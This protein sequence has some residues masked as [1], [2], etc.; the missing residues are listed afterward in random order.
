MAGTFNLR[1][2]TG[3]GL[4]RGALF[5]S[6]A[7][8]ELTDEGRNTLCTF[9]IH[10]VIDLRDDS[11]RLPSPADTPWQLAHLDI[12]DPTS[13]LAGVAALREEEVFRPD[14]VDL[15]AGSL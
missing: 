6:A 3:P 11:E 9:G 2:V 4:T 12:A 10:T 5:R 1:E 14:V 7:L 13:F 8:D 15:S